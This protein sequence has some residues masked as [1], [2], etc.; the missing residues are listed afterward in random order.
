MISVKPF[1]IQHLDKFDHNEDMFADL[2]KDMKNNV[3]DPKMDILSLLKEED[4]VAIAGITHLCRGAG[5]LWIIPGNLVEVYKCDFF[6]TIYRLIYKFIFEYY[7][8]HRLEINIQASWKKG[9]KWAKKLG[10]EEEGI[11]RQWDQH[12]NDYVRF[13]RIM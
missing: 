5:E 2:E 1:I 7:D 11:M 8:M 3:C 12:R 10:F 4:L 6:K 13:V 9:L